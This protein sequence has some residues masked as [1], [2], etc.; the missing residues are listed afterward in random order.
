MIWPRWRRVLRV[1]SS[2]CGSPATAPHIWQV[3]PFRSKT[4][5][6]VSFEMALSNA[7]LGAGSR[8]RYWP[9]FRSSR[10]L[11]VR[12][13]K[14]S[15]VL[16]SRT[17]RAHSVIPPAISRSSFESIVRPMFWRKWARRFSRAPMRSSGDE[18]LSGGFQKDRRNSTPNCCSHGGWEGVSN[19]TIGRRFAADE[20]PAI[21]EP[22]NAGHHANSEPWHPDEIGR[23]GFVRNAHAIHSKSSPGFFGAGG[24]EVGAAML[25]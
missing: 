10:S 7:G 21:G 23:W 2:G 25:L 14:P 17:R 5:A 24:A 4:K 22:L 19:L 16:S 8:R 13:W 20:F 3:N 1:G 9:G 18:V 6:R 11:C 15:S 12:I